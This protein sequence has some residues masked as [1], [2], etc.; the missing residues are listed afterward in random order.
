MKS[1]TQTIYVLQD[2][3]EEHIKTTYNTVT[4]DIAVTHSEVVHGH[5][6]YD[7]IQSLGINSKCRTLSRCRH[8]DRVARRYGGVY[9][10]RVTTSF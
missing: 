8:A 1:V 5:G 9:K 7:N 4:I 2:H 10:N 6:R 3:G